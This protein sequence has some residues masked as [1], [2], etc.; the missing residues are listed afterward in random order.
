VNYTEVKLKYLLTLIINLKI[1][2]QYNDFM[3]NILKNII[4]A[5]I[6]ILIGLI[7]YIFWSMTPKKEEKQFFSPPAKDKDAK[8][9]PTQLQFKTGFEKHKKSEQKESS[10]SAIRSIDYFKINK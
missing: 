10:G 9:M 3:E 5:I 4:I 7:T 1:I 6:I 8:S 2:L